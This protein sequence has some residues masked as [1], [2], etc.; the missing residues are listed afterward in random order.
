MNDPTGVRL[1][2]A[3][4]AWHN[5]FYAQKTGRINN[6]DFKIL[7]SYHYYKNYD[8]D[9][10]L[11][12]KF[13]EPFPQIFI[14]SG[15]Y[16]A[17]SV[18]AEIDLREYADFLKRNRH[19]ITTYAN[20]DSIGDAARTL[21]N[22]KRL[23]DMG[24]RPLPVFHTGESWSYLE[25]Y[26]E[27]YNYIAL[28]GMVP[29]LKDH[30]R[31]MPWLIRA[32]KMAQDRSVFHGFGCT[33]FNITRSLPWYSIDSSSWLS[34]ARFGNIPLFDLKAGKFISVTLRNYREIYRYANLIREHSYEPDVFA[35][36]SKNTHAANY[37]ISALAYMRA[38]AWLRS[39]HGEIVIP[40]R[41]QR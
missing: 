1:H 10:V 38:E 40:D 6:A 15:A 3:G 31:L 21:E 23:E 34:G 14:D 32:F 2:L 41:G 18:G 35:E 19:R 29:Y 24:L 9:E 28:G 4:T 12:D 22:Q 27:N 26:I 20:L 13:D 7:L 11:R 5:F 30:K 17:F 37:T 39:H 25:H 36:A 33:N 8:L 16:S